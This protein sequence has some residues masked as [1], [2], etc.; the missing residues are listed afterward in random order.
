MKE[1]KDTYYDLSKGEGGDTRGPWNEG[2]TWQFIDDMEECVAV[3]GGSGE[4]TV[5]LGK[6]EEKMLA[7][8]AKRTASRTD[9]DPKTGAELGAGKSNGNGAARP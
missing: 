8:V 1:F 6:D 4:A 5:S 7:K 3:D 9:V 2:G